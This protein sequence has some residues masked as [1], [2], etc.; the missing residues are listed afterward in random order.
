MAHRGVLSTAA[1][2]YAVGVEQR[3]LP[4]L[5]VYLLCL[6]VTAVAPGTV[7]WSTVV[8]NAVPVGTPCCVGWGGRGQAR[9][10]SH[11]V[12]VGP[13]PFTSTV[14]RGSNRNCPSAARTTAS[15]TWTRPASPWLSIRLARFTVLPHRS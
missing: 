2:I 9:P 13:A 4:M 10:V 14:P 15:V 12:S 11:Q 3:T 1:A 5:A 6:G 8:A 7:L